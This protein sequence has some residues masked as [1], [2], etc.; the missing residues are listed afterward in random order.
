VSI[1]VFTRILP[2]VALVLAVCAAPAW[3]C[4]VARIARPNE[5]VRTADL[6]VRARA[7]GY[8][9]P[10][11]VDSR[12]RPLVRFDVLEVVHGPAVERLQIRGVLTAEDDYN[13]KAPP[14]SFVRPGGRSGDCFASSYR[15]G[16]QY[17]LFLKHEDSGYTP[18][19]AP[20][21][22]VNEQLRSNRDPWLVWVRR[23]IGDR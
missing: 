12:G 21:A 20:L 15:N 16:G 6:I 4:S 2:A 8:V 14:Y 9:D 7:A 23:A 10:S 19:W 5:L 22:P 11:A 1:A 3:A 13:D 17:L 18:Y